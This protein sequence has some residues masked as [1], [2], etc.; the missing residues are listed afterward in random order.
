M[1]SPILEQ[2]IAS[3]QT[4]GAKYFTPFEVSA[5]LEEEARKRIER[6]PAEHRPAALLPLLL[7]VQERFGFISPE[8]VQWVA[9]MLDVQ[10]IRV[11]EVV[12]FYPG[13]RQRAP[14]RFHFRVCRTLSCAMGGSYELMDKLCELTG[15][16]RSTISHRNPIAVSPCGT[17]SVEFSECLAACGTAPVCMVNDDFHEEVTPGRAA[18]LIASCRDKSKD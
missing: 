10:P 7:L 9:G 6:Y 18:D 1:S 2:Q 8:A 14:G 11:E 4:P 5:E 16:D 12:T 13:L 17:W 15:I 3:P